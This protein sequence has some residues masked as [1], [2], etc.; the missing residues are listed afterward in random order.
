MSG[1]DPW[2][3]DSLEIFLDAGNAKNGPYRFDDTQIRISAENV[4]SFG[5]GDVAFQEARLESE[6]ASTDDGYVVEAP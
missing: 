6:T 2:V 5:T 1:S 3:Q 4:T